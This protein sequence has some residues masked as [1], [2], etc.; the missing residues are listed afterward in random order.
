MYIEYRSIGDLNNAIISN[1]SRFQQDFDLV[2]GIPRSG[3]LPA[4]LI[5][6]YL[7]KPFTDIDSFIEGR[8]YASGDRGKHIADRDLANVLVIDDSI[9]SGSAMLRAKE[10]I[11]DLDKKYNI[12]YGVIY[13]SSKG[14]GLVDIYCE[15]IDYARF[16]QWNI[17]QHPYF[18]SRSCFDIDGVL[19][20]NPPL[21]DDGP[22]Y[23]EYISNA[24]PLY[25]P[26]VEIDT[27]V[28]CRLEKYREPT[29]AWL[30]KHNVRYKKLVMLDMPTREARREW[31][32]HGIYKGEVYKGPDYI[33]FVESS[34]KEA[35]DIARVSG[36]PV[37]CTE[38]FTIINP[39]ASLEKAKHKLK[40]KFVN[41]LKR[42]VKAVLRKLELWK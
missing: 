7:N 41:K 32:K 35:V 18:V 10:K 31:G 21:D 13:A 12:K 8:A 28:T 4:N 26:T 23:L 9:Q 5:A 30:K 2:V 17:F 27:L 20:Q 24:V 25:L 22:I 36:K 34:L 6:L 19:C 33:L 29:E 3:M 42:F 1:L 16:F 15:I 14:A 11:G 39:N 40:S 37:F 38:N